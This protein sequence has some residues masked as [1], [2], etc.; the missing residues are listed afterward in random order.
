[1]QKCYEKSAEMDID[2]VLDGFI[3]VIQTN[4]FDKIFTQLVFIFYCKLCCFIY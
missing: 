4:A 2:V 1:M 3:F